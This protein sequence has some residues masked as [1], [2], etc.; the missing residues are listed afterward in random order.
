MKTEPTLIESTIDDSENAAFKEWE[1]AEAAGHIVKTEP[2]VVESTSDASEN[3]AFE[4][5]EASEAAAKEVRKNI[6]EE[7]DV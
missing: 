4:E 6:K 2:L 7:K 1:A 3:A 5:W